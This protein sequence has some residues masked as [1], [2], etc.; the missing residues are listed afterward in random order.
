MKLI[1]KVKD[2]EIN[3]DDFD[4]GPVLKYDS[5]NKEIIKTIKIMCEEALKLLK[6]RNL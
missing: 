1:V 2:I 4:N 3:I 5:E 6:E